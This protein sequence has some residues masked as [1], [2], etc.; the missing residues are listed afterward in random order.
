MLCCGVPLGPALSEEAVAPQETPTASAAAHTPSV[1]ATLANPTEPVCVAAPTTNLPNAEKV[2]EKLHSLNLKQ[3]KLLQKEKQHLQELQTKH[4]DIL[5][6]RK[7]KKVESSGKA[8]ISAPSSNGVDLSEKTPK[9]T[10]PSSVKTPSGVQGDPSK[11]TQSVKSG[12]EPPNN[13]KPKPQKQKVV[14]AP[15]LVQ[16]QTP[17]KFYSVYFAVNENI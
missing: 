16:S 11:Q 10:P 9:Q 1:E 12:S 7:K 6:F 3:L 15:T 8:A 13:I 14:P 5:E 4:I 17:G 2:R